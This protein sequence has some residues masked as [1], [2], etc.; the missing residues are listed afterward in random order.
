MSK[1][2]LLLSEIEQVPEPFLDEILDFVHFLR[3][4]IIK[5][6]MEIAIA[7]QSSLRK[8]WLRPEEDETWQSL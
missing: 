4:K 5:E 6:G 3:T 7:S 2:E 8:D 1:K